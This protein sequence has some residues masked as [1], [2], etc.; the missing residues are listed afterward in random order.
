MSFDFVKS[1][2]LG[3]DYLVVNLAI[4]VGHNDRS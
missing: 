4:D 1:H 2:G 3:N